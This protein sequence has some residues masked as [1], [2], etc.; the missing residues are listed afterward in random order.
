MDRNSISQ[1]RVKGETVGIIGLQAALADVCDGPI[2]G[3]DEDIKAELLERLRGKNYIPARALDDYARAFLREYKKHCGL[4]Y[5]DEAATGGLDIAI[6]GPGCPQCDRM[7]MEVMS[8]LTELDL[9]ASVRHVRDI[10]EIGT[11]GVMGMPAL[12]IN[13]RVVA[14]GAALPRAKI[15]TLIEKTDFDSF[16]SDR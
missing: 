10:K 15:R 13:G 8:V 3:S 11:Y 7:E 2:K 5:E 12:V 9:S 6:L 4:P 1:I 16:R 14:V